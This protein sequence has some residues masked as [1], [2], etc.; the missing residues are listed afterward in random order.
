MRDLINGKV[1]GALQN[2]KLPKSSIVLYVRDRPSVAIS[3]ITI[4]AN[5]RACSSA[6]EVDDSDE[7][8][9][10]LQQLW[11]LNI[12]S[13]HVSIA[14]TDDCKDEWMKW[15]RS[16]RHTDG[17]HNDLMITTAESMKPVDEDDLRKI[18]L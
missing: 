6:L 5:F 11:M 14:H 7:R 1:C 3:R 2:R 12:P 16:I 4:Q 15:A 9:E 8:E 17:V 18:F 10:Q 13:L